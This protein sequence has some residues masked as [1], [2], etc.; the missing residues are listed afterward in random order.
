MA[1]ALSATV[2]QAVV[3]P[4][5]V[6]HIARVSSFVSLS[7]AAVEGAGQYRVERQSPGQAWITVGSSSQPGFADLMP[8]APSQ[9]HCRV[10]ALP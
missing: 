10:I 4:A 2:G 9:R 7:W 1:L 5:P 3:L 6:L 8:A